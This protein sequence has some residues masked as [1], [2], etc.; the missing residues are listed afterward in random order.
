MFQPIGGLVEILRKKNAKLDELRFKQLATTRTLATRARTVG[1]Y[2]QLVMA[3]SKGSVNRLDALLRAAINRGAG[4]RGMIEALDRAQKGLYKPKNFTEE[5]MSRGL[6]FLRLG[7]ARV[8]SLAHQS[9]GGPA[10]S[11]LRRG[12]AL[13]PLSPSVGIPSKDEIRHNLQAA[14]KSP[15]GEVGCGYVLMIDEIK[16]EERLRWDPSSNKILGLCREHTQKIGVEFCSVNDVKA[17]TQGILCAEIHYATEVFLTSY[18]SLLLIRPPGN[19]FLDWLT[20]ER[21][22]CLRV[23]TLSRSRNL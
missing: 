1:Q 4:V 2:E 18:L 20:F 11:T 7:G 3:M 21:Q 23:A 5:E 22:T 8:A 6:L 9:L 12:S 10:V 19:G 15:H 17:I 14:F 16:V 13:V